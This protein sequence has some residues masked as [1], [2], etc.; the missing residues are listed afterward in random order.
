[1]N[2]YWLI[3]YKLPEGRYLFIDHDC[4][5]HRDF[6]RNLSRVSKE[7]HDRWFVFPDHE[8]AYC[9]LTA[10]MFYCDTSVRS[11]LADLCDTGWVCNVVY[12]D[13]DKLVG[14]GRALYTSSEFERRIVKPSFDDTLYNVVRYLL[15]RWPELVN[16]FGLVLWRDLDHV[17]Q[18]ATRTLDRRQVA[19]LRQLLAG[20]LKP[21]YFVGDK[22]SATFSKFVDRLL[23]SGLFQEFGSA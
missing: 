5:V 14:G 17:G 1:V 23:E 3:K 6:V 4:L 16:K 2:G 18:G 21:A 7:M 12:V 10:P 9:S 8:G 13:R 15:S 11:Y 20:P 19:L 22:E